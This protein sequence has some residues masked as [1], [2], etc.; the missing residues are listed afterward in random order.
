MIYYD[1]RLPSELVKCIILITSLIFFSFV[2]ADLITFRL[3]SF[4]KNEWYVYVT[5][6]HINLIINEK[7]KDC[8][9]IDRYEILNLKNI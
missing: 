9:I 2:L 1:Y 6:F 3:S 7:V 5:Y 4:F 8:Y